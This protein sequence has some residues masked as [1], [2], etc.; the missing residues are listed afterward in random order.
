MPVFDLPQLADP[1]LLR[2]LNREPVLVRTAIGAVITLLVQLG[3][4]IDD[5]LAHAITGVVVAFLALSAR[6][7]VTPVRRPRGNVT[8]GGRESGPELVVVPLRANSLEHLR[9]Q[10]NR[11]EQLR[12]Q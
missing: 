2:L 5:A 12:G 4:P 6:G 1:R 8:P 7:K 9:Q 3:L 11:L 10:I